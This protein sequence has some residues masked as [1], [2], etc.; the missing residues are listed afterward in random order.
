MKI[1]SKSKSPKLNGKLLK[2]LI[3]ED[4]IK[5]EVIYKDKEKRLK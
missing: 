2:E 4:S 1:S 5:Y 3:D